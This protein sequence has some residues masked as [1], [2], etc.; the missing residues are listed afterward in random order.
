MAVTL[1]S[2]A[3]KV[4]RGVTNPNT[5]FTCSSLPCSSSNFA[6]EIKDVGAMVFGA[7]LKVLQRLKV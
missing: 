5:R 2:I 1:R 7:W 4:L 3:E 6:L